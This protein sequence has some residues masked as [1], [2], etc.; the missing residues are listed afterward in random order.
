M[1]STC[2]TE[3][4]SG[5][6]QGSVLGSLIFLVMTTN[7]DQ[8]IQTSRVSSFTDNTRIS[9][10]INTNEDAQQLQEDLEKIYE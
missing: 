4:A 6:P 10:A 3:V 9:R 7:T 5:V 1:E 8:Q 2:D